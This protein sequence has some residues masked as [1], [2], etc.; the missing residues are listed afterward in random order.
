MRLTCSPSLVASYLPRRSPLP[1][2]SFLLGTNLCVLYHLLHL[3]PALS[4]H[5]LS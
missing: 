1:L 4:P 3:V 2:G 5:R